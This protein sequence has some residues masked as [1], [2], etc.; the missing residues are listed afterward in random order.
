MLLVK[1]VIDPAASTPRVGLVQRNL[2]ALQRKR[3]DMAYAK[4]QKRA[5]KKGRKIPP[6][7][8]YYDHWGYPYLMY[9]PYMY[10]VY[11][12]PGMYYGA[13][14]G[15]LV[16]CGTGATGGCVAGSCGYVY[17]PYP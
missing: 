9:G 10:P 2:A 16:A 11:W 4:A 3:L 14:P 1:S 6:R 12:T 5:A 17:C 7:D 13:Y 15:G 8:E